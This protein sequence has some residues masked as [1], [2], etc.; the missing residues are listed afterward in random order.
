[1]KGTINNRKIINMKINIKPIGDRVIV[2]QDPAETVTKS[3]IYIPAMAQEKPLKGTIVAIG[4]GRFSDVINSLVPLS[5]KLGDRV[6]YG[7]HIGT[8]ITH[9]GKDYLIM[10]EGDMYAIL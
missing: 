4:E 3:G 7:K 5:V 1:M 9:D 10:K 8:E 2:E 6:L